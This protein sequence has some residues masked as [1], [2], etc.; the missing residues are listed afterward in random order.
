MTP[1]DLG[2]PTLDFGSARV[3]GYVGTTATN[4]SYDTNSVGSPTGGLGIAGNSIFGFGSNLMSSLAGE[5]LRIDFDQAGAKFAVT[6][7]E[8]GTYNFSGKT[9]IEQVQFKFYLSN[10]LVGSPITKPGCNI[11][12]GLASYAILDFRSAPAA[13]TV[14]A[15]ETPAPGAGFYWLVRP[16]GP[17]GTWSSGGPGESGRDAHLPL[18]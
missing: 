11:D 16:H 2:T 5:F 13:T 10:T 1:G 6:L 14:A 18:P 9:Y 3:T 12:G 4:I 17:Q 15:P 7:N 8:F